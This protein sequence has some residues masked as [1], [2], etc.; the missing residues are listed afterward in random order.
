MKRSVALVVS[1]MSAATPLD[2]GREEVFAI[3]KRR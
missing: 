1:R 3:R 2:D